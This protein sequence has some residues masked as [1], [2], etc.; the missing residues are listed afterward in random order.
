MSERA[1]R[2]GKRESS[3]TQRQVEREQT[4]QDPAG[5]RESHTGAQQG[6][7]AIGRHKHIPLTAVN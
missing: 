6:Q 1:E 4:V 3:Q 5:Q 7:S 2:S